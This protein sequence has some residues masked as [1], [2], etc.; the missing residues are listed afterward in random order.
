ME[1]EYESIKRGDIELRCCPKCRD[2]FGYNVNDLCSYLYCTNCKPIKK[3]TF[4]K[5]KQEYL[6]KW[7][8][9]KFNKGNK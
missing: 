1:Y 4:T 6:M 9:E 2:F 5:E 3:E 8:G 7:I